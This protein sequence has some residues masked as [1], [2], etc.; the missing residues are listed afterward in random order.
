MPGSF[1]NHL[2]WGSALLVKFVTV[3]AVFVG[4][5]VSEDLPDRLRA[6][7][8][9]EEAFKRFTHTLERTSHIPDPR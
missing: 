7:G 4:L 8:C 2:S 9:V 6:A 5:A 1:R 3:P